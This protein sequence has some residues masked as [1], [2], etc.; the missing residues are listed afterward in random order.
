MLLQL[1]NEVRVEEKLD[2]RMYSRQYFHN[3]DE[4]CDLLSHH[5]Q[6]S[7]TLHRHHV[8]GHLSLTLTCSH[9]HVPTYGRPTQVVVRGIATPT[10]THP[11]L[12]RRTLLHLRSFH[13]LNRGGGG[14]LRSVISGALCPLPVYNSLSVV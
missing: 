8:S 4:V 1:L 7:D 12:S 10:R 11:L 14:S 13:Y 2:P 9:Y 3:T 5:I 6:S